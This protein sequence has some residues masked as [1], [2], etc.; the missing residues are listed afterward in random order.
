[1]VAGS[2][3]HAGT[4]LRH[5]N[6]VFIKLELP[7][8]DVCAEPEIAGQDSQQAC[9]DACYNGADVCSPCAYGA[10]VAGARAG[11]ATA[12]AVGASVGCT[13]G[14]LGSD[15]AVGTGNR[16]CDWGAGGQGAARGARYWRGDGSATSGGTAYDGLDCS[17]DL[18]A[19]GALDGGW[20][21]GLCGLKVQIA[22]PGEGVELRG[23]VEGAGIKDV[24]PGI[25][26]GVFG[27][28]VAAYHD[29]LAVPG[30][31]CVS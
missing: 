13:A 8:V 24:D 20:V 3:A 18:V 12:A 6:V 2:A 23:P 7:P 29:H 4:V 27:A 28:D 5:R 16:V 17:G 22:T 9:D 10:T 15:S 30:V 31:A 14:G 11:A 26:A 1:M 25:F 19:V 21:F